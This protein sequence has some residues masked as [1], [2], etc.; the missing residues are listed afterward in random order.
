MCTATYL[1]EEWKEGKAG[2]PS[3]TFTCLSYVKAPQNKKGDR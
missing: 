1:F 3:S 2:S